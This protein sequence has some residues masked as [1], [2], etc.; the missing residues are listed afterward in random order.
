MFR[1]Q[2]EGCLIQHDK[3]SQLQGR[4][5]E[6]CRKG[7]GAQRPAKIK[8]KPRLVLKE[9]RALSGWGEL[10]EL[11]RAGLPHFSRDQHSPRAVLRKTSAVLR[12]QDGP[13]HSRRCSWGR[14]GSDLLTSAVLG[15]TGPHL[16]TWQGSCPG[17]WM[18]EPRGT[19]AG[20]GSA[21]LWGCWRA[22]PRLHR[23]RDSRAAGRAPA[24]RAAA[25]SRSSPSSAYRGRASAPAPHRPAAAHFSRERGA[26]WS[27]PD[28]DCRREV[29]GRAG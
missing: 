10:Q 11:T 24:A 16:L 19:G 29:A 7:V 20:R 2:R 28:G 13:P 4:R 8:R 18:K 27:A 23:G 26:P 17:R 21:H 1:S 3:S 25:S 9:N 6:S 15:G 12:R 14:A 22:S 5:Q